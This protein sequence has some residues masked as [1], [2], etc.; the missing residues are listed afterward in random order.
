M[1]LQRTRR[2][3]L[4]EQVVQQMEELIESGE[5]EVGSRI[6]NELS[7]SK[8]LGVS[9]NTIR[10][11]VRALVYSGLLT[12]KQGDGT[13]VH[14][15]SALEGVLM[16][17]LTRTDITETLEVRFALEQEAAQLAALRRTNEELEALR[18]VHKDLIS[19]NV[20][21][22]GKDYIEAD[23]TFHSLV[24]KSSHNQLLID[25]YDSIMQ[26]VRESISGTIGKI[27]RF[28][29]HPTFNQQL[30]EAIAQ[31]KTEAA[32]RIVRDYIQAT[33]TAWEELGGEK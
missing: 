25:L 11:A 6:P 33:Q 21:T 19:I 14:S 10:E 13:F 30:I 15:N 18:K 28:D 17:R 9:R 26:S 5:W 16:R 8:Q 22:N 27:E 29:P 2:A 32:S 23:L 7:L 20:E 31:K 24:V 4:V 1:E 12:V 3:S